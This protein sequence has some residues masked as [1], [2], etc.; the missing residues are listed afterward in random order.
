MKNGRKPPF[1]DVLKLFS[2]F[3]LCEQKLRLLGQF[4]KFLQHLFST[5]AR[6]TTLI[7]HERTELW[8][9]Y[10]AQA[11]LDRVEKSSF[12]LRQI[13]LILLSQPQRHNLNTVVGLDMKFALQTPSYPTHH[14][15]STETFRSL[16][17]TFID[18]KVI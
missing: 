10:L 6:D 18:Q 3:F 2:D 1:I 7:R 13:A 16:R 15:N 8:P 5:F 12:Q 11:F 9:L 4:T 14:R 17:L